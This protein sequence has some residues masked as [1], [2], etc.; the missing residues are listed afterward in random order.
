MALIRSIS[1]LRGTLGDGLTPITVSHYTAAFSEYLG[2]GPV[3]V[4]R[5]GRPSGEWIEEIVVGTLR[6]RGIP[7]WTLGIVPTPTV[8]FVTQH[9]NA[10]GGISISASHNPAEWNGLKFLG[11]DGTFLDS[12]ACREFFTVADRGPV[13]PSSDTPVAPRHQITGGVERHLESVLT[14]PFIN[15]EGLRQRAFTVVVDAVNAAG[16][17]VVPALLEACGCRVVRLFCDGT[18]I[19]PHLPE[20]LPQNLT[21]LSEA[22][23]ANG[24][25]LGIAVDPDAD[26]LVLV[27]E[28]GNPIGE[29]Y[30]IAAVVDFV[31]GWERQ[32]DPISNLSAVINLSTTRAVEDVAARYGAAVFRTPVGEINVAKKMREIGAIIGGEGSGGV[33][34]PASHYGRD[35]LVGIAIVLSHLLQRGGT[36]SQLRESLPSYEI[37]KKRAERPANVKA[38]DVL[39]RVLRNHANGAAWNGQDGLR[40][41]FQQSWVHLRGSNTE[42]IIRVIAEAATAKEAEQL[43][44]KYLR[45]TEKIAAE[46]AA[47]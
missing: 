10:A 31:L 23:V 5:D 27:D 41:E 28:K 22:V 44:S 45:H 32:R 21:A 43:A 24:A 36:L 26:R 9:S 46:M 3:V 18:G 6:A 11:S 17:W 7:V 13:K 40:L 25:D 35:A 42:P 20:P 34:L 47:K 29:E 15:L 2:S 12:D 14:L 39:K 19:F 33:I 16:S 30:T 8:Q 1:G 38:V 37:V 4:G